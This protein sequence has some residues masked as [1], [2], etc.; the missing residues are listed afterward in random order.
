MGATFLELWTV[1]GPAGPERSLRVLVPRWMESL[2]RRHRAVIYVTPHLGC[3]DVGA[4]GLVRYSRKLLVYAKAQHSAE[5]DRLTNLQRE[6]MGYRVLMA[7]HGD[8]TAAVT[9][10][11]SLRDGDALGLM[12]DQKPADEESEPAFYLGLPTNCHRGPSFFA[13]R[14]G[15]VVVPGFCLRVRAGESVLFVGRPLAPRAGL[16]LTQTV[17]D[18]YSAMV[19]AFPGQYFWHHKRFN[20]KPPELAARTTEPWRERGL[21]LLIEPPAASSQSARS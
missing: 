10:M 8:R 13:Q 4:H 5:V 16:D 3:W 20:G 12:A 11:R 14:A 17:M 15:A 21:R 9:A 2:H 6:R 1:G 7:R 18:W 19:S